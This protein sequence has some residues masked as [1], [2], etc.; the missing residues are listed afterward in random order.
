[1][2]LS[3][4]REYM[5]LC[6]EACLVKDLTADGTLSII[7]MSFYGVGSSTSPEDVFYLRYA[8]RALSFGP[9]AQIGLV[10]DGPVRANGS[11]VVTYLPLKGPLRSSFRR[12]QS[13][14]R[15]LCVRSDGEGCC[16]LTFL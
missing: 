13:G 11:F 7:Y 1:M 8:N 12:R 2:D 5:Y 16:L 15:S 4:V 6:R 3:R 9:N 10:L 14:H